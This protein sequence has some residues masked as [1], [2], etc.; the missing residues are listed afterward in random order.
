MAHALGTG[1]TSRIGGEAA[2][3]LNNSDSSRRAVSGRQLTAMVMAICLAV[4]ATPVV[5]VAA[6]AMFSSHSART[7]AVA[8]KNTAAGNGAKAISGYA[9]G[10]SGTTYGVYGKSRSAHGY[11]I[12]SAG[13]LGSSGPLVCS[14]CVSGADVKASTLPT[15]PSATDAGALGGHK[16][17]Y[18]ARVVPLSWIGVADGA[19]HKIADLDGFG[20]Y[21]NCETSNSGQIVHVWVAADDISGAGTVNY[22][23]AQY[24]GTLETNGYPVETTQ[25]EINRSVSTGQYEGTAIYRNNA[26]GRIITIDTHTYGANCEVFGDMLTTA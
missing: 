17:L 3:K 9:S 24:G 19:R 2:M 5:A 14:H 11:G 8:A 12:Y 4:I 15:V 20:V 18:Y 25:V 7:P 6:S 23:I 13:R 1:T 21:G 16:P 26:T 10:K 22:F